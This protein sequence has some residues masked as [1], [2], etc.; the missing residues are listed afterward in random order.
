MKEFDQC[1]LF[2]LIFRFLDL[3]GHTVGKLSARQIQKKIDKLFDIFSV[4]SHQDF[5]TIVG[6]FFISCALEA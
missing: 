6:V 2:I 4:R 3:F 1:I 5:M